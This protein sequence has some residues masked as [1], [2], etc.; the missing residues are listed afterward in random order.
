MKQT[1]SSC[2]YKARYQVE[3]MDNDLGETTVAFELKRTKAAA[4]EQLVLLVHGL[5]WG[6]RHECHSSFSLYLSL[7]FTAP[8]VTGATWL[9]CPGLL[10]LLL[11]LLFALFSLFSRNL[12]W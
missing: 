4:E 8:S 3:R 6:R 5:E 10:V 11:S 2:S 1:R 9:Y 12:P 7:S